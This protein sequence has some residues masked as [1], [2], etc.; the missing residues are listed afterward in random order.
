M[1]SALLQISYNHSCPIRRHKQAFIHAERL[2]R[3]QF[4][5]PT[6]R[7]A[8]KTPHP[9]LSTLTPQPTQHRR[10]QRLEPTLP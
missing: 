6:A 2:S 4:H 9:Q 3:P 10:K 5:A 8:L 1:R 7:W